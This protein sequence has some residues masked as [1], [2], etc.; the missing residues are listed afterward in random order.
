MLDSELVIRSEERSSI[1]REN[2]WPSRA[3]TSRSTSACGST[4]SPVT[5]TSEMV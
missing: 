1:T 2:T 3:S 5:L 4:V